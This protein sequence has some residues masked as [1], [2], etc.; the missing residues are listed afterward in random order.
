MARRTRASV[1]AVSAVECLSRFHAPW[2][3]FDR[4]S[5]AFLA[6]AKM[7]RASVRLPA[8]KNAKRCDI[9]YL[10]S[11]LVPNSASIATQSKRYRISSPFICNAA[12][13]ARKRRSTRQLS[14]GIFAK[15]VNNSFAGSRSSSCYP[16]VLVVRMTE[17]TVGAFT[18][19]Y[20]ERIP[21]RHVENEIER[22]GEGCC[23]PKCEVGEIGS[24]DVCFLNG[25]RL[26]TLPKWV[27]RIQA[28]CL[29]IEDKT[30]CAHLEVPQIVLALALEKWIRIL[31]LPGLRLSKGPVAKEMDRS[32]FSLRLW[33]GITVR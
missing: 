8:R 10:I 4:K 29:V 2:A 30:M 11:K 23:K 33:K 5:Y 3:T 12:V 13:S 19:L 1:D 14:R 20:D 9:R 31:G 18:T 17:K 21:F 25:S 6:V 28:V 16:F 22:V 27:G 7:L 32:L 15:A 24:L 26:I